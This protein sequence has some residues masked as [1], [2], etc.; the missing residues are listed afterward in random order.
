MPDERHSEAVEEI[1]KIEEP[2]EIIVDI[3]EC[4]REGRKPPHARHYR[5]RIDKKQYVVDT[6]HPTGRQL[7][8]LAGKAPPEKWILRQIFR[9]GP[10]VPIGLEQK[11][12]LK[13]PGVEKF[14]TMPKD[15][16]DGAQ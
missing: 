15:I 4:S 6:P 7:L 13:T 8:V 14:S 1:E 3:E 5:I 11:V 10:A 16:S 9:N 12:D 2:L